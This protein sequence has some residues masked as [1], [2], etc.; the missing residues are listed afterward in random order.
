[1][2]VETVRGATVPSAALLT[3]PDGTVAVV[4]AAGEEHPVT[5]VASA[6]GMSLIEGVELGLRVRLPGEA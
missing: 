5:V 2:T 6:R 3:H 1:V 4:D